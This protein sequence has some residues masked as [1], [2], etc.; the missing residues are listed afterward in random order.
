[1]RS[2]AAIALLFEAFPASGAT[3]QS[4]VQLEWSALFASLSGL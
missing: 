2:F 4:G 1:M 3:V